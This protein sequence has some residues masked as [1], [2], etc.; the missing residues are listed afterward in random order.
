MNRRRDKPGTLD[1]DPDRR[2]MAEKIVLGSFAAEIQ[3]KAAM[4]VIH[5]VRRSLDSPD[6]MKQRDAIDKLMTFADAHALPSDM[7]KLL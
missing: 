1:L 5:R 3:L 4:L 2:A 6:P 7:E